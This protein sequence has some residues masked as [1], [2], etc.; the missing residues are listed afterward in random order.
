M[1]PAGSAVRHA[2][3]HRAAGKGGRAVAR[4]ARDVAGCGPSPR[5]SQPSRDVPRVV[6]DGDER[7]GPPPQPR[8]GQPQVV[9]RGPARVAGA[10][11]P[12]PRGSGGHRAAETRTWLRSNGGCPCTPGRQRGPTRR[13]ARGDAQAALRGRAAEG[14]SRESS[15]AEGVKDGGGRTRPRPVGVSEVNPPG[16]GQRYISRGWWKALT[17]T[18][19]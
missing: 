14:Q 15:L 5:P 11:D 3:G 1:R 6:A 8:A 9:C 17:A 16:R 7:W 4:P 13:G 18:L 10:S 19:K 12:P 2:R